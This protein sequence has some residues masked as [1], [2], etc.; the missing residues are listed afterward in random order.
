M[1]RPCAHCHPNLAASA[2]VREVGPCVICCADE[3]YTGTC[4]SSDPRALC[5]KPAPEPVPVAQDAI[6]EFWADRLDM[7][8]DMHNCGGGTMKACAKMLREQAA[9]I[10][11][12]A[13][14]EAEWAE[15][16]LVALEA[17]R[18]ACDETVAAERKIA[19]LE[20]SLAACQAELSLLNDERDYWIGG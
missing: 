13:R 9:T 17:H 10:A 7:L 3:P 5:N 11:D 12:H 8:G 16:E 20:A 14:R 19:A 2:Q 6:V 18:M 4:G 1:N 15:R